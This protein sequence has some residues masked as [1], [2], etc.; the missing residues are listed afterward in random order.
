MNP[1]CLL[2]IFKIIP[3]TMS[4][5][6]SWAFLSEV[7]SVNKK[8]KIPSYEMIWELSQK[9]KPVLWFWEIIERIEVDKSIYSEMWHLSFLTKDISHWQDRDI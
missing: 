6:A 8:K 7:S 4:Y 3:E 9:T 5:L 2:N 1:S